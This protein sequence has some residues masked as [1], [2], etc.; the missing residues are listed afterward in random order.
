[1]IS[2]GLDIGSRN[3]KIVFLEDSKRILW[4]DFTATAVSPLLSARELR[5]KG[6]AALQLE[7]ELQFRTCVTGY[8]RHLYKEADR[9]LSEINCH[10]TGIRYLFPEARTI[11]D[12]GGQ[13][14]KLISLDDQ[15]KI[16]DFVM[17]DK[18]AAGTGR[19]LEMTALRLGIDLDQLSLLAG[20]ADQE[21]KLNSTCVVFAES[22]I[23]GFMAQD[24]LPANIARA[25]N[26]SIAR[27]IASQMSSLSLV[28]PLVF[29]GGVALS[30]DIANCLHYVLQSE[31]QVPSDPEIT[32]ALGAAILASL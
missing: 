30:A 19:F 25:V 26:M 18:C 17:N 2:I 24:I 8:G 3:T 31:V 12:I 6:L 22:E 27:R 20:Q 10:A 11:I 4:S 32:G 14:S 1:M 9:A 21:L 7:E 16:L 13:D 15:G 29:T 23:I 5:S 28:S